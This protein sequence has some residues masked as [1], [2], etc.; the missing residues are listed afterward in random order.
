MTRAN[1]LYNTTGRITV[2]F[3]LLAAIA[4]LGLII[5]AAV[6]IMILATVIKSLIIIFIYF[7]MLVVIGISLFF[8][9]NIVNGIHDILTGIN[10]TK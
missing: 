10:Q 2:S 7:T 8:I 5:T 4:L 6:Q 1:K 9:Y 3:G